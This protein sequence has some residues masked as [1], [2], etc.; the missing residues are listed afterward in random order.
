MGKNSVMSS[1]KIWIA[2]YSVNLKIKIE[3]KHFLLLISDYKCGGDFVRQ[4]F[5]IKSKAHQEMNERGGLYYSCRGFY[6]QN[7]ITI[8]QIKIGFVI[9][10]DLVYSINQ[11]VG[12]IAVIYICFK[13]FYY[14]IR[15]TVPPKA[16]ADGKRES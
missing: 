12:V 16:G 13:N 2:D 10:K 3:T 7:L 6:A 1:A 15:E 9:N 4:D 5:S 8:L 11:H 14:H